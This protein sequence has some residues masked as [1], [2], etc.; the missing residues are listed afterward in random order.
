MGEEGEERGHMGAR[1]PS[2]TSLAFMEARG[3]HG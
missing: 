3:L 2:S 1:R